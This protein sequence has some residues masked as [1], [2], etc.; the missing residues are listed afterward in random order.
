MQLINSAAKNLP[1][2]DSNK[3]PWKASPSAALIKRDEEWGFSLQL[4]EAPSRSTAPGRLPAPSLVNEFTPLVGGREAALFQGD[5]S[6][7]K[8]QR[9]ARQRVPGPGTWPLLCFS[10][11]GA[12]DAPAWDAAWTADGCGRKSRG[13]SNDQHP[14]SSSHHLFGLQVCHSQQNLLEGTSFLLSSIQPRTR[15]NQSLEE[16]HFCL[17]LITFSRGSKVSRWKCLSNHVKQLHLRRR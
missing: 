5:V 3:A 15:I 7:S 2:R 13:P 9:V 16:A 17:P 10:Y 6:F 11:G 4:R 14:S 12:G 1:L 8:P